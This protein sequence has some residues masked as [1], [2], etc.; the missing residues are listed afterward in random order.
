MDATVLISFL[1]GDRVKECS[2]VL[3]A[4]KSRKILVTAGHCMELYLRSN[5]KGTHFFS[6]LTSNSS[7]TVVKDTEVR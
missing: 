2:A 1:D 7:P 5:E 4:S 6:N 3:V